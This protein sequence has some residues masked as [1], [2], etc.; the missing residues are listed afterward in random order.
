MTETN[1]KGGERGKCWYC[2]FL[3]DKCFS[4]MKEDTR[5]LKC[6][7]CGKEYYVGAYYPKSFQKAKEEYEASKK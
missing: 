6:P 7:G 5:D 4:F 1:D 3:L 2:G